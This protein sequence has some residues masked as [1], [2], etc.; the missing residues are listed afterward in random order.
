[1]HYLTRLIVIRSL[2]NV[3][4]AKSIWS[5]VSLVF[6]T[7]LDYFERP[8]SSTLGPSA[9]DWFITKIKIIKMHSIEPRKLINYP[10]FLKGPKEDMRKMS[11]IKPT[12]EWNLTFPV[13]HVGQQ[14]CINKEADLTCPP[15]DT[16]TWITRER[17][18]KQKPLHQNRTISHGVELSPS[19]SWRMW[20]IWHRIK[21]AI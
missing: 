12:I 14:R 1:M 20:F 13:W 9:S 10:E 17:K 18:P 2:Y 3:Q 11:V 21:K 6:L 8:S 4:N 19:S 7:C 5:I 16:H 15:L